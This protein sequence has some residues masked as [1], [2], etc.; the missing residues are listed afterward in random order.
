[1]MDTIPLGV[2]AGQCL[3]AGF[4]AHDL[5]ETWLPLLKRGELGGV[6]W[7]ARNIVD[8]RQV[9]EVNRR[10]ATCGW[11]GPPPYVAVDQE[12]GRVRRLRS[13]LL[14]LPAM[15]TLARLGNLQAVSQAAA[16]CSHQLRALGF[17][18]NFAPV[19]DVDT[20]PEN[21]IIGDRAFSSD[22][23]DVVKFAR[24]W[25]SGA[26]SQGLISCIKHFPGHGDTGVDSHLKLPVVSHSQQRLHDVE[27]K[28]FKLLTAHA[29][30]VMS[31]HI[32]YP[33]LDA[34]R[35]ATLSPAVMTHLLKGELGY[36]G[37]VFSDDLEMKAVSERWS[38]KE[39]ARLAITAGCDCVLVCSR[40]DTLEETH[41]HL[42][43]TAEKDASFRKRLLDAFMRSGFVRQQFASFCSSSPPLAAP[44]DQTSLLEANA[45]LLE[46]TGLAEEL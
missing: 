5:P 37:V 36:H 42:I 31:A 8:H 6:I 7:F 35:P 3:V 27:L 4:P 2:L 28:P 12:G 21:P 38:I 10:I 15:R 23:D 25:L 1:M 29:P 33:S 39:A 46:Q 44:P 19:V 26:T 32:L 41:E 43:T 40:D 45:K 34:D 22:A 9:W 11:E 18:T 17:S 20:N 14:P 16:L 30:S 24:A 13:P